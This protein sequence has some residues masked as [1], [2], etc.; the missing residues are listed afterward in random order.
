M[1]KRLE[2]SGWLQVAQ[3]LPIGTSRR[4]KHAGEPTPALVVYN[5]VDSWSAYCWRCKATARIMK[6]H[7]LLGAAPPKI[8]RRFPPDALPLISHEYAHV[9][10]AFLPSKGMDVSYLPDSALFSAA[11]KRLILREGAACVGRDITGRSGAKWLSYT[12]DKVFGNPISGE[13]VVVVEDA[14]SYYKVKHAVPNANVV[15]ALG[16]SLT[17]ALKLRLIQC[18]SVVIF[19]DGDK[20]G[21]DGA[22]RWRF[23]LAPHGTPVIVALAPSGLD[24]KDMQLLDIQRHLGDYHGCH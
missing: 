17:P 8:E 10:Y 23:E 14:F 12:D 11:D 5:N 2:E 20:G 3:R 16:T 4:I 1:S 19:F 9:V 7:V 6:S 15:A 24:P 22:A 21:A 18:A 13:P